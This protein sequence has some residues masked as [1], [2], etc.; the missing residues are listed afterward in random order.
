MLE[1]NKRILFT[2][3]QRDI[4]AT[5]K[6]ILA[7][8]ASL[9]SA[10]VDIDVLTP[11]AEAADLARERY[12]GLTNVTV[13]LIVSEDRFW[14]MQ[15]RDG[16]AKQFIKLTHGIPVPES[17]MP[18]W[19]MV[20]YDDFLWN[21][22][23]N[24]FPKI[25]E[26]YDLIIFPVPSVLLAPSNV[27]DVFNTH[28]IFHA[29]ENSIP[30]LGIQVH[31]IYDI[32]HIYPYVIDYFAVKDELEKSYYLDQGID[33]DKIFILDDPIERYCL[34]TV[35]DVYYDMVLS[36]SVKLAPE[37]IVIVIINHSKNRCQLL[38]AID[39]V[40]K[41]KHKKVV[42]FNMLNYSVKSIHESEV[43]KDLVKPDLDQKI[44]VVYEA[45]EL[46]L[47]ESMM[48]A[49]VLIT[50]DYMVQT[51]V[52]AQYGKLGVVYN[53]LIDDFPYVKDVVHAKTKQELADLIENQCQQKLQRMTLSKIVEHI[54][55]ESK[56]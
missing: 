42:I 49:D 3:P 33:N 38:D 43:F 16:F 30:V 48:L 47:S 21:V 17:D 18:Y 27:G 5:D 19:E 50:T 53:P 45:N 37:D 22:S 4:G 28:I 41:V 15:Q 35:Q 39:V 23:T 1:K 14:T 6:R 36:S 34:C 51:C 55:H 56:G 13:K 32:P 2:L 10:D 44:G 31:P 11:N 20:A 54:G 12:Q 46:A 26:Q 29:R 52:A 9:A 40:S 8:A 25:E 7:V 24:V